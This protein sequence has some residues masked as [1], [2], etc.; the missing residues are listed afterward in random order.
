LA[1]NV[2]VALRSDVVA[3]GVVSSVVVGGPIT[4]QLCSAGVGSTFG[5]SARSTARTSR[6][7]R[8]FSRPLKSAVGSTAVAHSFHA[9]SVPA[10]VSSAHSNEACGSLDENVNRAGASGRMPTAGPDTTVVSGATVSVIVHSQ[11]AGSAATS[12]NGLVGSTSNVYGR[13]GASPV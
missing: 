12:R 13:P 1:W 3:A 7:W 2:N 10:G 8:P 11:I 9:G 5:G 4:V 6:W